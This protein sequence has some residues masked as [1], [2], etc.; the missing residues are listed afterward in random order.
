ME[1]GAKFIPIL[2]IIGFMMYMR[3]SMS[4][5]MGGMGGAGGAGGK[6]S[7]F[8]VGKSTA[9]VFN[10]D[11][12]IT[13][14]FD[15]VAGLIEAKQEV[16]EFVDF[17]KN[18]KKYEALGAKI[19]KGG[20]MHGPPGTGKTLLAKAVAGESGVPFYSMSG[21]DFMEMFVGVG[22]VQPPTKPRLGLCGAHS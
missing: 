18:P 11:K 15:D 9:K 13:T 22:P 8:S 10:K 20:I 21:A 12:K 7:P 14:R 4:G 19:P 5:G 2:L 3:R 17:L 16:S 1:E 6:K